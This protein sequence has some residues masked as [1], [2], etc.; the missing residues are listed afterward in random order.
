MR[1]IV[2]GASTHI[3]PNATIAK[4]HTTDSGPSATKRGAGIALPSRGVRP[5]RFSFLPASGSAK[6][7]KN[8]PSRVPWN[9]APEYLLSGEP[10]PLNWPR[11]P[12]ISFR[13]DRRDMNFVQTQEDLGAPAAVAHMTSRHYAPHES[14]CTQR[15]QRIESFQTSPECWLDFLQQ[16]ATL[17]RI[18]LVATC[19]K[20]SAPHSIPMQPVGKVFLG[21]L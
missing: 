20:A 5:L 2:W 14:S 21:L 13:L 16:I 19:Q 9:R 1:G 7:S 17:I 15:A 12:A 6:V 4:R 10:L 18:S 8:R 3:V 11:G